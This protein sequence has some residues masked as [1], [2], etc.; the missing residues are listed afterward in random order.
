MKKCIFFPFEYTLDYMTYFH[1]FHGL[2]AASQ[3]ALLFFINI[4]LPGG[5]KKL[6]SMKVH[7]LDLNA[8]LLLR[9]NF[10]SF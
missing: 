4:V 8:R 1:F 5:E 6:K 7:L 2:K 10:S 3:S 9:A